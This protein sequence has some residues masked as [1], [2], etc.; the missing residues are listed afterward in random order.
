MVKK[1]D[2]QVEHIDTPK[3]CETKGEWR[4]SW[5]FLQSPAWCSLTRK[6]QQV[7]YYIYTCLQWGKLHKKDTNYVALNNGQ[8]EISSLIIRQKIKMTSKT[9]TLA[10][11]KLIKV[12][13]ITLTRVGQNKQCHMIKVLYGDAVRGQQEE[14]WRKYPNKNWEHECPDR[15]KN[16]VGKD[17]RWKKGVSGNPKF[18]SHPTKVNGTDDEQTT[19]VSLPNG[20]ELPKYYE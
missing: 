17:S 15:P 18:N 4:C 2:K 14:R 13:L 10:I 9:Y 5:Y 19:K 3:F 6:E 8:I 1:E 20:N 12:G 11:K 7:F 16:L